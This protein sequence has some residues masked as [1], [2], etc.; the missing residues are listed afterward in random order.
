MGITTSIFRKAKSK[1]GQVGQGIN[2]KINN[3]AE[4][5]ITS[6]AKILKYDE[7]GIPNGISKIGY[8]VITAS[9]LV[10]SAAGI[11]NEN[12]RKHI[13]P[14]DGRIVTATPDYS[15][16]RKGATMS[17]PGGADGSLVFALDKTK[18]GGFL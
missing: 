10:S 3:L 11:Y 5:V 14:T 15:V 6:P 17:A 9:T 4:G 12:E 2:N 7:D 8:G 16:Y 13:G 1:A 18:N